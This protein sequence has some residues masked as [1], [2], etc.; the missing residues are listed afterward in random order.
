MIRNELCRQEVNEEIIC[1]MHYEKN[2][3]H[4]KAYGTK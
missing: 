2:S 4:I 1:L 3:F